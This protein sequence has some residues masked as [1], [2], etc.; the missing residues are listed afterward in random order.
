MKCSAFLLVTTVLLAVQAGAPAG[1]SGAHPVMPRRAPTHT[2][3]GAHKRT[4]SNPLQ[5]IVVVIQENRSMDDLF[6]GFCV[7]A[8]ICANTVTVDPVSGTPLQPESLAAKFGVNHAHSSFVTQFDNGAMDG[9]NKTQINCKGSCPYTAFDYAPASEVALYWQMATVDGELSDM[10]FEAEQG[11]SLPSHLYAIGAQSGGYDDDNLALAGGAGNC[12]SGKLAPQLN[13]TTPYPGQYGPTS[14]PCKDFQTIFDLLA[15]AGYTWKYYAD[16]PGGWW[17]GP[18]NIQHLYGS[19]NFILK[20]TKFL[21]DVASGNLADV[22]F[23]IPYSGGVSDHPEHVKSP[24]AGPQ[25]V[26][27]VVD[28]VGN[29]PYW[30]STAIVVYW[31]DWGGF[32]D[33][34]PPTPPS[35][36]PPWMGNP[37]PFEYGFRVPLIVISPYAILG[38]IDHEPRSFVSSLRLIEETFG[39]PSLGA[40]DQWEPDGLDTMFNFN[41]PPNPFVAIGGTDVQ[42]R[43]YKP[44]PG[45]DVEDYDL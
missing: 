29:S 38:T 21:S 16:K 12:A 41:Q 2:P 30:G 25:W 26:S 23:V 24:T 35:G 42:P 34:V 8:S 11:P 32:F 36:S 14:P 40:L 20:S 10:T 6:N 7:N 18:E 37:D 27:A 31:D 9:F 22:S 17:A 15:N 13:M 5:H 43:H 28:A 44:I 33:H 19:P 45:D 1:A 39:L 3:F 4:G